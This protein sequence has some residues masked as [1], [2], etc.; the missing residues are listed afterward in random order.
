MGDGEL[1]GALEIGYT[2]VYFTFL[3]LNKM[4][5]LYLFAAWSMYMEYV[6]A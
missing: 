5:F 2:A 3:P 1:M 4:T 6:F